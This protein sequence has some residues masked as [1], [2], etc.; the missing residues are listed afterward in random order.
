MCD[1]DNGIQ[2]FLSFSFLKS[3]ILSGLGSLISIDSTYVMSKI[4]GLMKKRIACSTTLGEE[5][6]FYDLSILPS[7]EDNVRRVWKKSHLV[8]WSPVLGEL[9]CRPK[10]P[11]YR[12]LSQAHLRGIVGIASQG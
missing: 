12:E 10:A 6:K 9:L 4:K 11:S 8:S 1:I 5:L 7:T 2:T 3:N